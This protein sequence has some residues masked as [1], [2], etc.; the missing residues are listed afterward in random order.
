MSTASSIRIAY[1]LPLFLPTL[2]GIELMAA[3]SLPELR[4]RGFEFRI[5]TDQLNPSRPPHQD[6]LGM[7]VAAFPFY[8]SLEKKDVATTAR[9]LA[10]TGRILQEFKPQVTHL[11]FGGHI[12]YFHHMATRN[13]GCPQLITLHA[14]VAQTDTGV[15]SVLG[16]ALRS[17]SHVVAVSQ[18]I[19]D[20]AVAQVP[21]LGERSSVIY[22]GFDLQIPG[23]Q[24]ATI[25]PD[26]ILCLGRLVPEKGFAV[27]LS[28]FAQVVADFPE[29]RLVVA[30]DGPQRAELETQAG[31]LG[32]HSQVVFLGEVAPEDVPGLIREAGMVLVPSIY[33]EPFPLV[34][35]EAAHMGRP[36]IAAATGGL[37]EAV[38]DGETGLLVKMGDAAD[39]AA[40]M[41]RL[42][43]NP[44]EAEAMG[45]AAHVQARKRF[46]LAHFVDQYAALYRRLAGEGSA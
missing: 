3:R 18:A 11:H 44:R 9:I 31:E 32:I 12:V 38:A 27:A 20:G 6:F 33:D 10:G 4:E 29:A 40:A 45:I 28:A 19:L 15:D 36:V 16:Q 23:D 13:L 7:P 34:A 37:P 25:Q 17:A 35:V 5:F 26:K 14:S 46:G 42:L 1:W 2:G 30:G 8:R 41:L 43:R 22:N 24:Q 39:L 21:E